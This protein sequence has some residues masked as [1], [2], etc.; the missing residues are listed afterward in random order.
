MIYKK[1]IGSAF[2][3]ILRQTKIRLLLLYKDFTYLQDLTNAK[4]FPNVKTTLIRFSNVSD[5]LFANLKGREKT[6]LKLTP[7]EAKGEAIVI[8]QKYMK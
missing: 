5:N 4:P 1:H 3:E 7:I 8:F 6:Y 2:S